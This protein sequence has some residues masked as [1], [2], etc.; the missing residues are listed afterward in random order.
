MIDSCGSFTKDLHVWI[1]RDNRSNCFV[2]GIS[3]FITNACDSKAINQEYTVPR[4][5]R[6]PPVVGQL[7]I[8]YGVVIL[9]LFIDM[10]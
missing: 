6:P 8:I 2:F 3:C 7:I 9:F 1:T 4:N 5:T 10:S